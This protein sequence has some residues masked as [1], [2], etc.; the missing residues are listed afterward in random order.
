[1]QIKTKEDWIALAEQTV[2]KLGDYIVEQLPRADRDVAQAALDTDLA[3]EDWDA[4]HTKFEEI[5]ASLPDN[6]SIRHAPFFDLCD[7]CSEYWVFEDEGSA[8]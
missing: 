5:W 3:N 7:L 2:P 1:M 4:L 6:P 8:D